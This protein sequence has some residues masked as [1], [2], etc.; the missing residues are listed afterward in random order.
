MT[1]KQR[2]LAG[3]AIASTLAGGFVFAIWRKMPHNQLDVLGPSRSEV[4]ALPRDRAL[5]KPIIDLKL[6]IV[7]RFALPTPVVVSPEEIALLKGDDNVGGLIRLRMRASIDQAA[8]RV[9]GVTFWSKNWQTPNQLPVPFAFGDQPLKA[10][11][12]WASPT[13]SKVEL[14]I[15][16]LY[17]PAPKIPEIR[18]ETGQFTVILV[19]VP[20]KTTLPF[21]EYTVRVEG[22][23]TGKQLVASV[24]GWGTWIRIPG[25]G[26]RLRLD[27]PANKV[28]LSIAVLN[29]ERATLVRGPDGPAGQVAI[30]RKDGAPLFELYG[31]RAQAFSDVIGF[32]FGEGR[33]SVGSLRKDVASTEFRWSG[34]VTDPEVFRLPRGKPF[35]A[36]LYRLGPSQA[37]ELDT[38]IPKGAFMQSF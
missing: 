33:F 19:P 28:T 30:N 26:S 1:K 7:G 12:R 25:P 22:D 16:A 8:Y 3:V 14:T 15:P 2:I 29:A 5:G 32:S 35:E 21:V 36:V 13:P 17:R 24:G 31:G 10:T 18:L 6:P 23:A 34:D 11:F 38:H 4:V 20:P 9:D 37:Y 27:P